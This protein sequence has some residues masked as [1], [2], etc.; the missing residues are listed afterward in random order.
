MYANDII[1]ITNSTTLKSA[2]PSLRQNK[3]TK[4]TDDKVNP[5]V[6]LSLVE[7]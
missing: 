7:N 5:T 6:G 3:M 2:P 4:Y 1:T